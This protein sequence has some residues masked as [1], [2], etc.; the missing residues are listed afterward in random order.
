MARERPI[1]SLDELMDGALTERFNYEMERVLNNV[2]DPN[3]NS[4]AKRQIQIVIGIA[5]NER[6]DAAEFKVDVRSKVAPP[7]AV[8]QTVFLSISDDG[9]VTAT[10]MTNQVRGQINM[11]GETSIPRVI[12]FKRADSK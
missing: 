2:F 7:S 11:D 1:K 12:E 4:K 10:E 6:R 9:I 3:T 5:P 8:T